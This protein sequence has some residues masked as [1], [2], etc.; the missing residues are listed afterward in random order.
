MVFPIGACTQDPPVYIGTGVYTFVSQEDNAPI[1]A[2]DG[3]TVHVDVEALSFIMEGGEA[4]FQT[5][6]ALLP[7]DEWM[8]NCPTNFDVVKLE[9]ME[10]QDTLTVED[11]ILEEPILFADGCVGDQGETATQLWLSSVAFHESNDAIGEGRYLL[12][13]ADDMQ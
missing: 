9:T 4:D 6:L 5:S 12:E 8:E 1:E 2:M 13:K 7:D 11:E 10:L 3:V